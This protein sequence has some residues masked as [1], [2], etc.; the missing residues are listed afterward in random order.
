M[1]AWSDFFSLPRKITLQSVL[2]IIARAEARKGR[3]TKEAISSPGNHRAFN[4][5]ERDKQ[6]ECERRKTPLKAGT[7][8]EDTLLQAV[9]VATVTS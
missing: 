2:K 1:V 9:G 7:L 8:R 3:F 4:I 6:K 5:T